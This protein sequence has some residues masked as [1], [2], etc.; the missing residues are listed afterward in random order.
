MQA[1]FSFIQ[2]SASSIYKVF[3]TSPQDHLANFV[4]ICFGANVLVS[5]YDNLRDEWIKKID[6]ILKVKIAD[7]KTM[8]IGTPA[9]NRYHPILVRDLDSMERAHNSA[10]HKYCGLARRSSIWF[11]IACIMVAFFN[12]Y[13]YWNIILILPLPACWIFSRWILAAGFLRKIQKRINQHKDY[14]IKYEGPSAEETRKEINRIN[15][16]I[17]PDITPP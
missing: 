7:V 10:Q 2:N 3:F 1:F 4:A 8:E 13:H 15:A 12:C 6:A 9:Q 5:V 14:M 16:A 17:S 11:A